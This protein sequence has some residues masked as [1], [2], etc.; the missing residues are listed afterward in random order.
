[1]IKFVNLFKEIRKKWNRVRSK[2]VDSEVA[3]TDIKFLLEEI[4]RLNDI[5]DDLESSLEEQEIRFAEE[6]ESINEV[7][8][9]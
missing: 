7:N 3:K 1:M 5:V 8:M 2:T 6:L 4:D 9:V